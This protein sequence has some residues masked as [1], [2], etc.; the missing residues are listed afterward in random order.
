M[1][2]ML[3]NLKILENGVIFFDDKNELSFNIENLFLKFKL[4]N[5]TPP[6]EPRLEVE[7]ISSK[8]A[9]LKLYDITTT[10]FG[11]FKPT[12][13]LTKDKKAYFLAF[14]VQKLI[15]NSQESDGYQ[16]TYCWYVEE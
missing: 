8:E 14:N 10:R 1:E 11:V 2:K 7:E 4:N 16:L 3:G 13:I 6:K 12:K 5:N 15:T 9:V